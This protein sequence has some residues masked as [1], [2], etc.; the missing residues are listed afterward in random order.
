M[1]YYTKAHPELQVFLCFC[2]SCFL[3]GRRAAKD[4]VQSVRILG[5]IRLISWISRLSFA[6]KAEFRFFRKSAAPK[7]RGAESSAVFT[8]YL[9]TNNR[10]SW[11][12]R[13]IGRKVC[14]HHDF[15]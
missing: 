8:F 10:V 4:R 13:S 11:V 14:L 9:L 5:A 6:G 12:I 1:V 7:S 3:G 15:V 2:V